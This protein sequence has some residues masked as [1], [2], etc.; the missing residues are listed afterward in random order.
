LFANLIIPIDPVILTIENNFR[1][2]W[3]PLSQVRISSN[4]NS[5]KGDN[6]PLF[7]LGKIG[8]NNKNNNNNKKGNNIDLCPESFRLIIT[9]DFF[10]ARNPLFIAFDEE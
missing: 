4:D 6:I 1:I 5:S 7:L 9:I 3:N 8:L 2:C 10:E